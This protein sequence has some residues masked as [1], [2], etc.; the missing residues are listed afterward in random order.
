VV[1]LT[2][3]CQEL[4]EQLAASIEANH[5]LTDEERRL[6]EKRLAALQRDLHHVIEKKEVLEKHLQP[7][8]EALLQQYH[9][10]QQTATQAGMPAS[11]HQ[12]PSVPYRQQLPAGYGE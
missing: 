4:Q 3:E 9:R 10:L 12:A 5:Q 11:T 1:H 2:W 7:S 8:I 6:L